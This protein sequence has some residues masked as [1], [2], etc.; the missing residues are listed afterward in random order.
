[1]RWFFSSDL[2]IVKILGCIFQSP[3]KRFSIL[4]LFVVIS[5]CGRAY[6]PIELKTISRSER[7]ESQETARVKIIPMTSRSIVKAN[8][9]P[10]LKRVIDSGSLNGP[11]KLLSEKM[12]LVEKFPANNDPGPYRV[13]IGDKISFG[14]ILSNE[15]N[16]DSLIVRDFFV[17]EDGVIN[18]IN[19][20][21]IKA[22]GLTQSQLEDSIYE[23]L[24]ES[25][26]NRNF[27]LTITGFNSKKVIVVSDELKLTTLPYL[28]NP[29]YLESALSNLELETV[30]G[31]DVKIVILRGGKEYVF[32]LKNL[33][34][35]S[36]FKYRLFPNDKILVQPLNYRV[37][38]VLIVG[39]TGTQK[40]IPINSVLRPTLSDTIFSGLV[41]NSV[42][43]DFSQIYVIRK[44]RSQF[45][46]FHLDITNPTRVNLASKF[47][48]R[49]DDIVFVA[50][51]PLSLYS[52]ALSQILGSTGLTI[53]AR[54][55]VRS[56]VR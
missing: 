22:E 14:Q 39:E 50:T 49:P 44:K 16:E 6:F 56:E 54:D 12:A 52:R 40:A 8:S 17:K 10:Y 43:S 9:V 38:T 4:I 2:N 26:G 36:K 37:E 29:I 33:L 34:K 1:M 35:N 32:S 31:A 3:L 46:A 25:D 18:I 42:T 19:V 48:M 13:G 23:K 55:T 27:E 45:N 20:G 5:S 7:A 21:R 11:A 28:S 24:L 41:L 15:A 30:P 51:Q 53:Q 47:E